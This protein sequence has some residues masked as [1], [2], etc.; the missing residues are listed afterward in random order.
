MSDK[1]VENT[2]HLPDIPSQWY[3]SLPSRTAMGRFFDT[4][5]PHRAQAL[6]QMWNSSKLA[7]T[8][9]WPASRQIHIA[10]CGFS[11]LNYFAP[12]ISWAALADGIIPQLTIG[13]YNQLFQ[14]LTK[15]DSPVTQ[16][17]V[18]IGWI[19]ADL[20]DLLAADILAKPNQLMSKRGLRAVDE[21]VDSLASS[22]SFARKRFKGFLL[23]NDFV[24][25]RRSPFGI[26]DASRNIP[27]EHIYHHA[28]DRLHKRLSDINYTGIFSLS[29]YIRRFG[30]SQAV[31]PRLRLM[32]D[33]LFTTNFFFELANGIRPYFRSLKGAMRKVLVL[34]LDN[35]LWG[36]VVGEDGWE[37][38]NIGTT[39]AGKAFASFQ[40]AIL[41]LYD[42]GVILAINSKNNPNDVE[43]LFKHREEMLLKLH[44]FASVQV[45]WQD[46]VTNCNVIAK[47]INVSLDSLVLWMTTPLSVYLC[48][49]T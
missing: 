48:V 2:S 1:T 16:E 46:K 38:V 37:G 11:T 41:E 27:F 20:T 8:I 30:L 32:G 6:L 26:A 14:D 10:L 44:H 24:P 31:D 7:S 13:S 19:W 4:S 18:E 5:D 47:E 21:A 25:M 40:S 49:K 9:D 22:L 28:N 15:S 33:C 35:T 43:E 17:K 39:P 29:Y 45:N 34:D 3:N 42:R 12:Y 23:V 36:G